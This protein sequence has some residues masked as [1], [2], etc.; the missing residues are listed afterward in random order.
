MLQTNYDD[1][2]CND[3][4]HLTVEYVAN[5]DSRQGKVVRWL[6]ELSPDLILLQEVDICRYEASFKTPLEALGYDGSFQPRDKHMCC[7]TFWRRSKLLCL[8]DSSR[9][10]VAKKQRQL[11]SRTLLQRFGLIGRNAQDVRE[12]MVLNVHLDAARNQKG[13][14]M[15]ARAMDFALERLAMQ[16]PGG[17]LL[18]ASDFNVNPDNTIVAVLREHP[19]RGF[20]LA[21]A[22]EHPAAGTTSI[23][24][25]ATCAI[26]PY[27]DFFDQ[28]WYC[29]N[30]LRL[31]LVLQALSTDERREAFRMDGPGL[32]NQ[33]V[34]SDHAPIGAVFELL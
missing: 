4:T 15:R 11:Q 1:Q 18:V 34:P 24:L 32:P 8:W 21:S 12:L 10:D 5:V 28:M 29:H 14:E 7:A 6:S 3:Y 31:R 22:Y 13:Q 19:W 25:E 17:P 33:V 30:H 23:V 9:E 16:L 20:Q 26:R 2:E 27:R